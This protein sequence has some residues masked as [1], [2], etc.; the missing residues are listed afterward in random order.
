M[1]IVL[2]HWRIKPEREQISDFLGYWKTQATVSDRTGLITEMLSEARSAKDFWYATWRLDPESFGNFKSYVNVGFWHDDNAFEEQI[3]RHFND[4]L[5][6][7]D[8]EKY[9]RRRAI[10]TPTAWRLGGSSLPSADSDG[11]L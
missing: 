8:F 3:A 6:M 1:M 10:L 7:K 5:P 11:V 2:I 9:R 4:D